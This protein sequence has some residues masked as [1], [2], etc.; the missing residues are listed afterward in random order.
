MNND[1]QHA[2]QDGKNED[3]HKADVNNENTNTKKPDKKNNDDGELD[4]NN[5][6]ANTNKSDKKKK[7][8]QVLENDKKDDS[9]S[10]SDTQMLLESTARKGETYSVWSLDEYFHHVME[11][12]NPL[13][14]Y[15]IEALMVFIILFLPS[16]FWVIIS[17][18]TFD[19]K[20]YFKNPGPLTSDPEGLFRVALFTFIWYVFDIIILLFTRSILAIAYFILN[21]LQLNESEFCWNIADVLYKTRDYFRLSVDCLLIFFLSTKMFSEYSKPSNFNILEH[22]VQITLVLWVGIYAGML[23]IM[24]IITNVLVYDVKNTTFKSQIRDLNQKLFVFRKLVNISE[25]GSDA[26][27]II[28]STVPEYDPGFY[29]R[30]KDLFGSK[31]ETSL[32][33]RRFMA[34]LKKKLLKYE[35]ISNYFPNDH[36]PV[37]MYLTSS[38]TVDKKKEIKRK[39]LIAIATELCENRKHMV[40]TLKDRDTIFEKLEFIFWLGTTYLAAIILCIL[41]DINY[42]F[43][44]FGVGTSLLTFSWIFADVI[45][46]IFHCFVFVLIIRPYSIGDRVNINDEELVVSKIDLLTS[47]FINT[48]QT[49]TYM[50]NIELMTTKIHN[51]TRSPPQNLL[52]EVKVGDVKYTQLKS[53]EG[54]LKKEV[55]K[56]NKHFNNAELLALA[57]GKALFSINMVKNAGSSQQMKIRKDKI[58]K[59]LEPLLQKNDISHEN[60]YLFKI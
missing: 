11:D 47:T 3:G 32:M 60:S 50:A 12:W 21:T 18:K 41:F 20:K 48:T 26:N 42:S 34:R 38:E 56:A 23:F 49:I 28:N 31:K 6:N 5:K 44:L 45:K 25:A 35:D 2:S 9:S 46:M 19:I 43:Y 54:S 16:L 17:W 15:I 52:V 40:S 36:D 30:E 1:Q 58:A 14:V 59:I 55:Q 10:D 29:P 7:E 57:D 27:E 22:N 53:M 24:K 13:I 39:A 33:V 8:P 37:F 51:L 4:A